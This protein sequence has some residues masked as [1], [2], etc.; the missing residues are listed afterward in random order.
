MTGTQAQSGGVA[1]DVDEVKSRY[2]ID[3][4]TAEVLRHALRFVS[5]QMQ[6]K[7]NT[8]ALSPLLSEVNDFGVGL[9]APRDLERDLDFDA[10]AMASAAPAH[11]VINQFYAR[12]AIEHWGVDRLQPGDVLIYNDPYRGGSHVN[13]VGTLMPIFHEDQLIGFAVAITHWLDIGG[14]V[15]AGL[16]AGLQRDM[17][18]EGIKLTPR[19]LYDKG[20]L[21]RETL[22]LFTEQTR[23]PD[24]T[25]NDLQVIKAALQLGTDMVG[26]Y[27]KRYGADAYYAASQYTLDYSERAVRSSLLEVPDGTYESQDYLDN[28]MD[29]EPML[30]RCTVRKYG[31]SIEV[32]YSGSCREEWGGYAS[33]WS[34]TV[35]G[36]H[37]GVANI[38]D[39]TAVE[40]NAGAYRPIH[41]VAPPGSC[42][43][44]LPPMSTNAGHTMFF[45]KALNLVK[46][47]LSKAS[48]ELAVAENYDDVGVLGFVGIDDRADTHNPFITIR[49]L[50]GPFG[51]TARDD[52]CSMTLVEGGNCLEPSIELD[53][54]AYPVVVLSREFVTDTAGVGTHRGG[55]STEMMLA[56]QVPVQMTYQLDQCRFPTQGVLG[57]G[58]GALASIKVHRGGLDAWV[59]GEALP[60]PEVI[61]GF[62]YSDTGRLAPAEEAESPGVE[63]RNS[64]G[65]GAPFMPG[66]VVVLRLPG[67]GGYGPAPER[68]P[69]A[70]RRDVRDGIYSSAAAAGQ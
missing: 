5:L 66:D 48:P 2:G 38:L 70:V 34:D 69:E 16:G 63:F 13:D 30:V 62:A 53:E 31:D 32:D 44:A 52:G 47:A 12:M 57:G 17:Y 58:N 60:E 54:E 45:T 8:A 18:A 55:P 3:L 27:V 37:L 41:V 67:A 61:A 26:H 33:Q 11:Y 19:K 68:D 46:L 64:K 7:I 56:P 35:S 4:T 22:E 36:A 59:R 40:L 29:G 49:A 65:A 42:L 24:I 39:T 28:N 10:I 21:V 6:L 23:I 15:P 51:G 25:I 43:S 1:L 9:L 20:E 50:C 14:P